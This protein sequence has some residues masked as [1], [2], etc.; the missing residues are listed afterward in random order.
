MGMY[1]NKAYANLAKQVFKTLL[2]AVVLVTGVSTWAQNLYRYKDESGTIVISQSIPVDRVPHGY[3]VLDSSGRVTQ[4]VDP[5]LSDE[6]YEAKVKREQAVAN[7]SAEL[8]RVTKAYQ[9]LED[10]DYAEQQSIASIE[11][12]I[13]NARA[14][15]SHAQNQRKALESQAAQKDIEGKQIPQMLLDDIEKA[16]TQERNLQEEIESRLSEKLEQTLHYRYDRKIFELPN[17]DEGLPPR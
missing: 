14:N 5:Q 7:C 4:R 8:K 13:T 12:S 6:E 1:L 2:A 16:R 11:T 9:T 3:E 15:L 17:C 10:I